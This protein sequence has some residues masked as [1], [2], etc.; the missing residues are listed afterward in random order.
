MAEKQGGAQITVGLDLRAVD[1]KYQRLGRKENVFY[2][3]RINMATMGASK[4][5]VSDETNHGKLGLI[6]LY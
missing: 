3:T 6:A 2:R 4:D 1:Q 5:H